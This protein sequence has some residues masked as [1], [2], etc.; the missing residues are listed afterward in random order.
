MSEDVLLVDSRDQVDWAI[1]RGCVITMQCALSCSGQTGG[2]FVPVL[3]WHPALS[4]TRAGRR[5]TFG[6]PSARS[7]ISIAPCDAA[8]NPS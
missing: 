4:T 1:S 6:V 3:T 8:R 7:A 5:I 2:I